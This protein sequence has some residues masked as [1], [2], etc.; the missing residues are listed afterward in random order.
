MVQNKK[1]KSK[2]ETVDVLKHRLRP[3]KHALFRFLTQLPLFW[4]G[5]HNPGEPAVRRVATNTRKYLART[6]PSREF[7]QVYRAIDSA[8]SFVPPPARTL[9]ASRLTTRTNSKYR[10]AFVASFERAR[11]L[12]QAGHIVTQNGTLLTDLSFEYPDSYYQ[13]GDWAA[14]RAC[15]KPMQ[16]L[17]GTTCTLATNWA[18]D[19]YFHFMFELLPR[20]EMVRRSGIP[21]ETVDYFVVNP[22]QFQ[23]FWDAL[24]RLG[25]TRDRVKICSATSVFEST[26]V[27][28]PSTLRATGHKRRWVCEWLKQTFA[29]TSTP[30]DGTVRLYVGRDDANRRHLQNQGELLEQVLLPLGFEHVNWDGRSIREQAAL[31]ANADIVVGLN[32]AALTNLVFCK[33]G[34][35]V[36]VLHHPGKL[37][38][39]FYELCH[40]LDLDYYYLVGET[41]TTTTGDYASDYVVNPAALAE[42]L[43]LAQV[44]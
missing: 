4:Q 21:L 37:S 14:V 12:G 3:Y 18:D 19:N 39:Y 20:C 43:R 33:P 32:G 17:A 36:L 26:R 29:P 34:T 28:A 16:S 38:R 31:F 42:L 5:R 1:W 11:I 10:E 2:I 15:L 25:I 24:A 27:V 35:R 30:C 8:Q 7:S 23:V 13:D 9:S 6:L 40:T 41:T 44:H 22:F